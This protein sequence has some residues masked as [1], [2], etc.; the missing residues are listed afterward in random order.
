MSDHAE[1]APKRPDRRRGAYRHHSRR[2]GYGR[3]PRGPQPRR[4]EHRACW[5][6]RPDWSTD[7]EAS[8]LLA[9]RDGV[10]W[11]PIVA[12]VGRPAGA[13]NGFL[14]WA[15]GVIV[16]LALGALGLSS[17][18]GAA[19]SIIGQTGVPSVNAPAVDASAAADAL[20]NSA[21]GAF[22][23]LAI[24]AIAA[25]LGGMVGIAGRVDERTVA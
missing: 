25:T 15:L 20:R 3:H 19:G 6:H 12:A 10:R 18:L 2:R 14:V 23:S 16:I 9:A 22:I 17:I 4:R 8:A 24:P 11:G 5:H 13:L 1:P 7:R 21:L